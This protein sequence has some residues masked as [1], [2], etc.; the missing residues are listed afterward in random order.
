MDSFVT[1]LSKKSEK[2]VSHKQMDYADIQLCETGCP[3]Q[4]WSQSILLLQIRWAAASRACVFLC[5]FKKQGGGFN[6]VHYDLIR[7]LL[8]DKLCW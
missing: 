4:A 8:G 1:F 6:L 3:V 7:V 2:Q 5:G